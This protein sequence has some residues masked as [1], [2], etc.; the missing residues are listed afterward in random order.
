MDARRQIERADHVLVSPISIWETGMLVG[1]GRVA[2]DRDLHAWTRDLFD[3]D[4][5]E[6]AFL[7]PQAAATAALLDDMFPGDPADRL[8]YATSLDLSV[9]LVTKDE[10]VRAFASARGDV[11]TVW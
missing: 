1:K 5:I 3:D 8:L 2:L 7:T 9:P 4:R 11:R 10:Q 6:A